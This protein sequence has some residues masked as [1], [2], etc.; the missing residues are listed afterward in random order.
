MRKAA[1]PLRQQHENQAFAI[2]GLFWRRRR[3][4][5]GTCFAALMI[6]GVTTFFVQSQYTAEVLLKPRLGL[7]HQDPKKRGTSLDAASLI[8]TEVDLIQSRATAQRVV[9]RLRLSKDP[10]LAVNE[11][12]PARTLSL[13]MSLWPAMEKSSTPSGESMIAAQLMNNLRVTNEY[14]SYLIRVSY[15]S[16]S[17][18]RAAEIAN[19]F[20]DEYAQ[21]QSEAEARQ[22]LADL[23]SSYGPKH[24]LILGAHARLDD[25]LRRSNVGDNPD[26]V[27]QSVFP[28]GPNRH[29][30]LG[31]ALLGGLMGGIFI[32]LIRERFRTDVELA[33]ETNLGA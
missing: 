24:P 23:A 18:G 5:A 25:A 9:D 20:A 2:L 1:R 21:L 4:I 12:L 7:A 13:F 14:R 15:S 17:P 6:G 28:S 11:S 3:I 29:L 8:E 31:L 10:A 32:V 33:T 26:I 22:E 30:I 27:S 19:A 16:T